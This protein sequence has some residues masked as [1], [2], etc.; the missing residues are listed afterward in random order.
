MGGLGDFAGRFQETQQNFFDPAARRTPTLTILNL[1]LRVLPKA[2][3][4]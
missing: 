3:T 1:N 2:A 4:S